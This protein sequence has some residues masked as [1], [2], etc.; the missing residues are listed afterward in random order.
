M[1]GSWIEE[2][3]LGERV[4]QQG[5]VKPS[6]PSLR[7]TLEYEGAGIH[8]I[9]AL[10]CLSHA[11]LVYGGALADPRFLPARLNLILRPAALIVPPVIASPHYSQQ[12]P[13]HIPIDLEEPSDRLAIAH[14]LVYLGLEAQYL[15]LT[16]L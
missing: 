12:H 2:S 14:A 13:E 1:F 3:F 7:S 4:G 11:A 5:L 10:T 8:V 9:R 6:T 15:D 16:I